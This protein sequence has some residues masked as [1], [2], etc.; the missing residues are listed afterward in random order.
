[1]DDKTFKPVFV[2]RSTTHS[3]LEKPKEDAPI[4]EIDQKIDLILR[5]ARNFY[6]NKGFEKNLNTEVLNESLTMTYKN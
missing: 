6:N 4:T 5:G 3:N 2:G 1:M